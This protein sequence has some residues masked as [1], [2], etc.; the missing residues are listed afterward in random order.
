MKTIIIMRHG[1]PKTDLELLK[2]VKTTPEKLGRIIQEYENCSL[3]WDSRPPQSALEVAKSCR[4]L[5]SSD[6]PRA[7]ES[8]RLLLPEREVYV[9]AIYRESTLPHAHWNRPQLTFF[10]WALIFR[11]F[12]LMGFSKNGES[13]GKAK[14]R[15]GKAVEQII[16]LTDKHGSVL[17][18][19]HGII[20]RLIAKTLEAQD[21]QRMSCSGE[22]YWAYSVYQKA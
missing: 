20:N 22:Q 2:K 10:T 6:L 11:V 5:V 19:G 8:A 7:Q 21:W 12:W 18:M 4:A 1:K 9:D 16:K 3:A 17:L 15:A 14:K 13:I